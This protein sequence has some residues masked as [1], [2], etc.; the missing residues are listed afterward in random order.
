LRS[1]GVDDDMVIDV[2]GRRWS[3]GTSGCTRV[4]RR[5]DLVIDP[6]MLG[7]LVLG[8]V[9]PQTLHAGHRLDARSPEALRR[10]NALFRTFPDPNCQ[11][12]I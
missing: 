8:G 2:G 7:A 1:Y 6:G 9:S 3:V 11:T 5:P 4:R 10:A 12:P